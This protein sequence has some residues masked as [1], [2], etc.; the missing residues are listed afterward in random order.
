MQLLVDNRESALF[1]HHLLW[2]G[3][4]F[5]PHCVKEKKFSHHL[6][7]LLL[8]DPFPPEEYPS[9]LNLTSQGMSPLFSRI[10]EM[11]DLSQ[12]HKREKTREKIALYQKQGLNIF[13]F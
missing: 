3:S 8:N 12:P 11:E 7:C 2:S 1:I 9:I 10:Y 4:S 13:S 6:I 5:Y